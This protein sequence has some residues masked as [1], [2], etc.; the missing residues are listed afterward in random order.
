[1]N[2]LLVEYNTFTNENFILPQSL[3]VCMIRFEAE[4]SIACEGEDIF[5]DN[6]KL[7]PHI[8]EYVGEEREAGPPPLK[9]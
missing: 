3:H 5:E 7:D 1:M 2:S 9:N 4:T 6:C 8:K